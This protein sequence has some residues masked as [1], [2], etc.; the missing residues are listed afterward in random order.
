[1]RTKIIFTFCLIGC[2]FITSCGKTYCPG[3]PEHL[4]DYNPYKV[5][6]TLSFVN[7]YNDTLSFR[8]L[9]ADKIEE[10]SYNWNCKC[11]CGEP[12]VVFDA[13]QI[14]KP[15]WTGVKVDIYAA[16]NKYKKSHISFELGDGYLDGITVT[17]SKLRFY[18]EIGK[19]PFDPQNSVLFGETVILENSEMQISRAVIVRGKG[20]TEFY[21][22]KYDFHW[23]IIN[24]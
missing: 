23:K 21:D 7:Q 8:V 19:D 1:M 12:F 6:D 9:S 20:I 4:A 14:T 10:W 5:G 24:K 15:Q 3:F 22:Q 16:G 2:L 11:E 18:E 13:P 17:K